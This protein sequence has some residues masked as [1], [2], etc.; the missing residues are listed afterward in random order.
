MCAD[1]IKK[2]PSL[3]KQGDVT[4]KR[5]VVRAMGA[6]PLPMKKLPGKKKPPVREAKTLK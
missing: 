3:N 4:M 6:E 1:A 5:G 2:L